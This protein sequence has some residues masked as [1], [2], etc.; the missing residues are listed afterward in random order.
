MTRITVLMVVS[1]S[2]MGQTVILLVVYIV[3][4]VGAMT[5]VCAGMVVLMDGLE[6]FVHWNVYRLVLTANA[7]GTQGDA[8]SAMKQTLNLYVLLQVSAFLYAS[9]YNAFFD[10]ILEMKIKTIVLP[11]S[12]CAKIY[13]RRYFACHLRCMRQK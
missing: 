12:R 3:K 11:F 1:S 4:M 5:K 8:Q 13:F 10:V 2:I 6:T 7:T 9:G